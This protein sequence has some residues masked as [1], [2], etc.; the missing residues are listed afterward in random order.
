MDPL[1]DLQT[2]SFNSTTGS[3][4]PCGGNGNSCIINGGT[5][6]LSPLGSGAYSGLSVN[7]GGTL[8]LAAGTYF[9]Y[10]AN[11]NFNGGTVTGTGVTLVLLGSSSLSINGGNVDLSAPSAP[12]TTT[13]PLNGVL[14][15]D[16]ATGAVNIN[17]NSTVKL[18]GAM[19]FPKADVSIGGT[20]QPTNTTC[21]EVIA[22]TLNMTGSA[23]LSTAGCDP[24][25]VA[26][27]QVVALVQ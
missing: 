5:T 18:A 25:V 14:I 10:N 3:T 8:N 1:Q 7:N 9:F 24:S 22:K 15:D 19:Y 4:N 12:R 23:Y 13:S 27:T 6:N 16:Q 20:V 26:H 11:I 21:S 17:G 2:A